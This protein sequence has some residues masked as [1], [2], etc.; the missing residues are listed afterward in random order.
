MTTVPMLW[1]LT[2]SSL[3][4]SLL[5]Q[6]PGAHIDVRRR[7]C[8]SVELLAAS[9]VS[10]GVAIVV[11]ADLPR[12]SRE[13]AATLHKQSG[14]LIV[15]TTPGVEENTIRSWGVGRVVPVDLGSP[16]D[17]IDVGALVGASRPHQPVLPTPPNPRQP[18]IQAQVVCMWSPMGST[19]RSTIAL[20]LAESWALSGERVLLI[21]A[22]MRAPSLAT[23]VSVM[24][25]VSGLVVACRYAD[26]H[27]LD[28]RTL[29]SAC[30]ELQP[31]LSIMTGLS[32][33]QRWAEVSPPSFRSVISTAREH[34]DRIVIDISPIMSM[35][36]A[37][38]FTRDLDPYSTLQPSRDA[39]AVTALESADWVAAVMRPDAVGA[40]RFVQD[41]AA[42]SSIFAQA[43][44]CFLLNRVAGRGS[45]STIDEFA[46]IC[47]TVG[48]RSEIDFRAIPEDSAVSAMVRAG[49]TF[50][51]NG[52]RGQAFTAVRKIATES[53]MHQS[54][55]LGSRRGKHYNKIANL[56][57]LV[58]RL[59]I[60]RRH[61]HASTG[62]N[63]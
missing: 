28:T 1:A 53:F 18:S 13:V 63:R 56:G 29:G 4:A 31:R 59:G 44:I 49:A 21:D 14:D 55:T 40:A 62:G 10:P 5:M 34:F 26:H 35:Y 7:C 9:A 30:R 41:F 37:D 32:D 48:T 51:E 39:V 20:G 50:T 3:E 45:R 15:L 24:E 47:A 23:S 25:D 27:A 22:D 42:H 54:E 36:A 16:V 11:Q 43:H 60:F 12:F 6:A 58:Q 8:D 33:P 46:S 57:P 17:S 61:A 2:D 52:R 38:E 19:G